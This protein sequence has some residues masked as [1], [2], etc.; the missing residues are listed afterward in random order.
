[1]AVI[2]KLLGLDG[3]DLDDPDRLIYTSRTEKAFEALEAGRCDV[4]LLMNPT[5]LRHV[6]EIS[7]RLL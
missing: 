5:R 6:E 3:N 1:M 7:D 2:E 4:A